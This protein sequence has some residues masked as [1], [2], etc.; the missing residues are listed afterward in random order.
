MYML[1]MFAELN[2][3]VAVCICFFLIIIFI[4]IFVVVIIIIFF[5]HPMYYLPGQQV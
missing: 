1:C 4:I 2:Y 5:V 3:N